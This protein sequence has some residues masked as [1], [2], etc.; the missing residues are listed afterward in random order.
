MSQRRINTKV[1]DEICILRNDFIVMKSEL[2]NLKHEL[3]QL[4]KEN[5][6]NNNN[7]TVNGIYLFYFSFKPQFAL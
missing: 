1:M 5:P 2:D 3:N 6:R 4:K 7:L